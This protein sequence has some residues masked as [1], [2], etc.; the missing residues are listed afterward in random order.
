MGHDPRRSNPKRAAWHPALLALLAL[1]ALLVAT[2]PQSV[3]PD[4]TPLAVEPSAIATPL[5]ALPQALR[6]EANA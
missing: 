6:R 1:P 4:A 2:E 5:H 3:P